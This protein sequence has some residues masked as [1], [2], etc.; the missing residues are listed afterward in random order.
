MGLE[1]A[2]AAREFAAGRMPVWI[3]RLRAIVDQDS[4]V[5]CPEGRE[6]VAE[7]LAGWA[8]EAGCESELVPTEAG[9]HLVARLYG[10][11][12]GRIVLL[13]H[14]DTV[15]E[16]GT[17]AQWPFS[18]RDRCAF[19][20]GVADMKGGLLVALLAIEALARG[21]RPFEAVELHSVPDEETRWSPFAA[22]D[23]VR[24]ARAA[25]VFE[26]GR[27]N[28]DVVAARKTGAVLRIEVRGRPAHAG[29]EAE[30]GRDAVLGLC[31]EVL[32]WHAL[33]ERRPGLSVV[34]CT[35]SGGTRVSV[36]PEKAEAMIDVRVLSSSD[37]DWALEQ[38]AASPTDS[39]LH[40]SV[41]VQERCPGMET[42]PASEAMLRRAAL[43]A[44]SLGTSLGGMTS[45]GMS[46]ASFTATAGIPTLDGLGPV[47]GKDHST[48][49]YIQLDSV[50]VRCAVV[51]GLCE[52]AGCGLF[53]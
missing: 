7:Q 51:A 25:L 23:L 33:N 12:K 40:V 47:G 4:G 31:A 1:Q 16:R 26:C 11:G 41:E 18:Q 21:K 45:G 37:L 44:S 36:V 6:R 49:E 29:T 15:F 9:S 39:D 43:I 3:D 20:P 13:G 35:I 27:E 5:D 52:A 24:G 17:C 2:L 30:R 32:R 22:F 50:P 19:G 42:T 38:I 48:D 34:T 28:G 14:H 46:D 10:S 53:H 8:E